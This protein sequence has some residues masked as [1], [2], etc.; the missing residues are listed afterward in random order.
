MKRKYL[1]IIFTAMLVILLAACGSTS[2]TSSQEGSQESSL[3]QTEATG[4][5]DAAD[6]GEAV[7]TPSPHVESYAPCSIYFKGVSRWKN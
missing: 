5:G 3:E 1:M 7:Q 6:A 4:D 2:D